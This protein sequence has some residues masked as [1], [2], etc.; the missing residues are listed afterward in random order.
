MVTEIDIPLVC[1]NLW[2]DCKGSKSYRNY[3][4]SCCDI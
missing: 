4:V 1:L 2:E 3:I